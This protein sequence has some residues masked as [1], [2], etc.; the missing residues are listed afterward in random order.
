M[1]SSP[2]SRVSSASSD[3]SCRSASV[4]ALGALLLSLLIAAWL[5]H[6]T[7]RPIARLAD[8]LT[9]MDPARPQ[10][11]FE[12]DLQ[13]AEARLIAQAVDGY[14]Q[15]IGTLLDRERSLTDDIS[16]ELRTPTSVITTA[17]ELLLDDATVTGAA[18]ER[19]GR[20]A[21]AARRTAS[22]VE[23]LLFLGRDDSVI[24][25]VSTDLR[26]VVNDTVEVYLPIAQAKGIALHAAYGDEQVVTV[27]A[28]AA[29]IVLQNLI[30]NAIRYTDS[31]HVRVT[32]APGRLIV[33][34]TGVGLAGVDKARIFE[35]GYRSDASHGSGLGLDLIRRVCE[36]VGWR[37]SVYE[38]PEGGSRFEV[39]FAAD[40]GHAPS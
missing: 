39:A 5:A 20:I 26:A 14:Q 33:E 38:R 27:P 4:T 24:A 37:V 8:R 12:A 25:P 32:L 11:L 34:D 35:R 23:A 10:S 16:H 2:T 31:G 28:G 9:T 29:S 3:G 18:R 17:S 22:V 1:R 6:T 13:T 7:L 40:A 21:R 19:V 30:E 36:R 15:R